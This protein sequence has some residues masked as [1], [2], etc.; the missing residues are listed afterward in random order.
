MH[1]SALKKKS[2]DL[3]IILRL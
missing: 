3:L 1:I 2:G